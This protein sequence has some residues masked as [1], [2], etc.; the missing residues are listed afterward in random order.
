M[1]LSLFSSR[2]ITSDISDI[3]RIIPRPIHENIVF[4]N[5]VHTHVIVVKEKN[6]YDLLD[7]LI[8]Q[9]GFDK[10]E[11]KVENDHY[12]LV[13][14]NSGFKIAE[15]LIGFID[16]EE[17]WQTNKESVKHDGKS[18]DLDVKRMKDDLEK[19]KISMAI[20]LQQMKND[21]EKEKILMAIEIQKL[22]DELQNERAKCSNSHSVMGFIK[23]GL[24]NKYIDRELLSEKIREYV[25]KDS[26]ISMLLS[27]VGLGKKVLEG[28]VIHN[29]FNI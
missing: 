7:K 2:A 17:M 18:M 11:S 25:S 3:F 20:E 5:L 9:Q 28:D 10:M 6:N 27:M 23:D 21:L 22:K 15:N 13:F 4:A 16:K 19:K 14:Q 26:R 12:T 29:L 24:Y 1:D 8:E